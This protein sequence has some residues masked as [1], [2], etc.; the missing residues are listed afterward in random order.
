LHVLIHGMYVAMHGR[1]V[2]THGWYVTRL[3]TQA[4]WQ[5]H[6]DG[7]LIRRVGD[8]M[9]VAH[10][11]ARHLV[12]APL[13]LQPLLHDGRALGGGEGGGHPGALQYRLSH[14]D[15]DLPVRQELRLYQPCSK[16][17]PAGTF[18]AV[19]YREEHHDAVLWMQWGA[20]S[21]FKGSV[22]PPTV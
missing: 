13:H 20:R 21:T 14:V 18:S 1:H 17:H 6:L 9:G 2:A 11:D 3:S 10:G 19:M 15:A 7:F 16:P 22:S 8:G 4:R 5:A 12:R